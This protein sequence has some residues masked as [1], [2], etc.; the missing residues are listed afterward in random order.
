MDFLLW[1]DRLFEKLGVGQSFASKSRSPD[2][3]LHVDG[4]VFIEGQFNALGDIQFGGNLGLNDIVVS[5]DLLANGSGIFASG[6][7]VS[8]DSVFSGSLNSNGDISVGGDLNTSGDIY[9]DSKIIHTNDTDTYIEFSGEQ[10]SIVAGSDNSVTIN[11]EEIDFKINGVSQASV[12]SSGRLS[13]NTSNPLGNLSVSGDSYLEKLYITGSDG[14]WQQL[15][16]RGYDEAVNF[17]TNLLSGQTI[18]EIDFP[19][20]F[21]SKPLIYSNLQMTR[22]TLFYFL[23]H[24]T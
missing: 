18:Y 19:K 17:S 4:D 13:V 21:G 20:T 5:G 6:I 10:V 24:L 16:P 8:G 7:N 1:S 15:V 22:L 23:I 11:D 3:A 14:S 2:Y 9:I 12:D